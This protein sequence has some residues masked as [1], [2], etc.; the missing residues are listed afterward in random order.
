MNEH[1]PPASSESALPTPS[2]SKRRRDWFVAIVMVTAA[3]ACSGWLA[4]PNNVAP[5]PNGGLVV[6]Q[7]ELDFGEEWEDRAFPW[8]FTIHN[9]TSKD[10]TIAEFWTTC[11]CA[12]V[13]PE[14]LTISAGGKA[15]VNAMLDLRAAFRDQAAPTE[16]KNSLPA[17]RPFEA[18]FIPQIA[19]LAFEQGWQVRGQ[20]TR[21]LTIL[22]AELRVPDEVNHCNQSPTLRAEVV[23]HVPCEG[24]EAVLP[25]EYGQVHAKSGE[26]GRYD[27]EITLSPLLQVGPFS[28]EVRVNPNA[29]QK[30]ETRKSKASRALVVNG[31]IVEDAQ[32]IPNSL[33]FGTKK[34]GEVAQAFLT[35]TSRS[36]KP[37]LVVPMTTGSPDTLVGPR[38][39]SK[40]AG[41]SFNVSQKVTQE[42]HA[43]GVLTFELRQGD[44]VYKHLVPWSYYGIAGK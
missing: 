40:E 28:F 22:P 8:K 29:R 20:V 7:K 38:L 4:Y 32:A 31:R 43:C 12:S 41:A 2:K 6:D 3:C 14:S 44:R 5:P 33:F 18:E 26:N 11:S 23:V 10:V 35:I 30:G 39:T 25:P 27:L 16:S 36:G 15:V 17:K 24:I 42:G 19:D 37:V 21:E 34:L 9:P 13:K 1:L